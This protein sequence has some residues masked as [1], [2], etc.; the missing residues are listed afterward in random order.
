MNVHS[1]RLGGVTAAMLLALAGLAGFLI[2]TANGATQSKGTVSLRSTK[3]GKILVSS[4]GHTLYLFQKD[5][6]G[7]SSCAGQCAKYWP[8]LISAT[9]PTAG[10]GV[11][12]ALLGRVRR[13]DGTMQVTYNRHP[14]YLFLKDKAAGQLTG[15][16]LDFFGG[17]WY[18]VNAK[19]AK[20][21]PGEHRGTTTTEQTTTTTYTQPPPPGY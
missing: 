18:V 14:L 20:V 2:A 17:E 21:E 8:P 15:E 11:K 5:K 12:T 19:G 9:K 10:T 13:S 6:S 3:L 16:N 4:N 1:H 7:R